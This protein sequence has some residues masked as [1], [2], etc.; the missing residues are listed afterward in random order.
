V[1]QHLS[2]K[3]QLRV[4]HL[5]YYAPAAVSSGDVHIR[6]YEDLFMLNNMSRLTSSMMTI[7]FLNIGPNPP[8]LRTDGSSNCV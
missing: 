6:K 4:I 5:G 1:T 2:V 3:Y 8:E 7:A